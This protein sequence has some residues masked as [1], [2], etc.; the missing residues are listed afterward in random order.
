MRDVSWPKRWREASFELL[1]I[2]RR[3]EMCARFFGSNDPVLFGPP[4]PDRGTE[5][6]GDIWPMFE[7]IQAPLLKRHPLAA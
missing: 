2:Q 4:R 3:D 5:R 1:S 7:P 6:S